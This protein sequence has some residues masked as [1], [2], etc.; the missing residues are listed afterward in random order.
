MTIQ[1]QKRL[2]NVLGEDCR[3]KVLIAAA[4]VTFLHVLR[5][6]IILFDLFYFILFCLL[7][8]II[9]FRFIEDKHR[10]YIAVPLVDFA[11]MLIAL[12]APHH[13]LLYACEQHAQARYQ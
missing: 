4:G 2:D 1:S 12:C 7:L 8:L 13:Y 6:R 5:V 9:L 11:S 3:V 10:E